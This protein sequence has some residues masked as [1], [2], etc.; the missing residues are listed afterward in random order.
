[1]TSIEIGPDLSLLD[2]A[3]EA[4]PNSPAVFVLWP[5]DGRPYVSK[6]TLLRRRAVAPPAWNGHQ[7][8]ASPQ[9]APHG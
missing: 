4:L 8:L 6:T 7:P 2:A 3:L 5:A 9:L 1:M